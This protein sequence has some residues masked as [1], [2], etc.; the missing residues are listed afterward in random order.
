MIAGIQLQQFR[1]YKDSS[2]EFDPGVNIIVGPNASGKTNLLESILVVSRGQS[3]R[4]K[5]AELL[6]IGAQW[7]R[8]DAR[9]FTDDVRTVKIQTKNTS[10]VQKSFEI[11]EKVIARLHASKQLPVVLFEP[12]HLQ[13][14][15]GSPDARRA[16]LD[17][18]IEQTYPE[19]AALRKSYKRVLIQRNN[20]LKQQS[21]DIQ[22]QLFVWNIRLSELGG[23]I[24]RY[25]VQLIALCNEQITELYDA[26]STRDNQIV[27]E[28]VSK[29]LPESYESSLLSKLESNMQ[30]EIQRGYTLYGP[31]RDDFV[32]L[33][34]GSR[35]EDTASRGEIRTL[36]LALKILELRIIEKARSQKPLL[37][38]DDVFSELDG[39]RRQALTSYV[40]Q[41]QT[42]ITT[43]DADLVV[44][45]FAGKASII[46][47]DIN[48]VTESMNVN[49]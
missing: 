20:L 36:L 4:V 30:L 33:I 24:A 40:S 2:F 16:Y 6:Q 19:Y 35:A 43:T 26:L 13:L 44:Q 22:K 7:A 18:L 38:L 34:D 14:L 21:T 3:Y 29:F 8:L 31:H 47:T 25:R 42:F 1:S 48:S 5:D 46:P 49:N 41:Y 28:Y 32:L 45:H 27:I 23:K 37:L 10:A 9:L 11:N 17:D 12:D 39:R 15:S